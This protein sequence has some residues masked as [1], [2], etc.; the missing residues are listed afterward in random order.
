MSVNHIDNTCTLYKQYDFQKQRNIIKTRNNTIWWE[1]MGKC[2]YA[3][4][5]SSMLR[6]VF[7]KFQLLS[8]ANMSCVSL[9]EPFYLLLTE[10]YGRPR[11]INNFI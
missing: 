4:L 1:R 3:K 2:L 11:N 7:F 8:V 5:Y 6:G 10:Y 9:V